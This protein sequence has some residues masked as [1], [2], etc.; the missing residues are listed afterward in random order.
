MQK[1]LFANLT[2]VADGGVTEAHELNLFHPALYMFTLT[3]Q[4]ITNSKIL[5]NAEANS[6]PGEHYITCLVMF[7]VLCVQA[8]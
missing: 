7:D 4:A 8:L 1:K 6:D 2:L 3:E 5:T